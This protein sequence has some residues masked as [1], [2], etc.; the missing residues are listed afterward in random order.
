MQDAAYDSLLKARRQELHGKIARVIEERWPY[1]VATEPELLAY[2][3]TEAKQPAK[4]IPLWQQAGSLAFKRMALAEAIAHLNKGLELVAALPPSAERDGME[5]DLRSL[6]GTAWLA[7]RG[8]QVQE[9]WD[10]LHPALELANSLRRNDAL[11]P[12]L[13]GL[14]VH[15]LCRG[16]VAESLRWVEEAMNAAETHDDP[17][18]LIVGHNA[19]ASAYFW[20]GDPIKASEHADRVLALYSEEGQSHLV[21]YQDPKAACLYFAAVS[22]W[23]LGYPDR[24]AQLRDES[25]AHARKLGHS[26]DLGFAL[27]EGSVKLFDC[28]GEPDEQLKRLV[29]AERLGRENSLPFLMDV[30]VPACSG[31]ALIRAGQTHDGTAS[32]KKGIAVWEQGGGRVNSPYLKYVLAEG[33]AQLGDLDGALD[34]LDEI[35]AQVERPGWEERCYYAE[36][37][38]TKG[39]LLSL[40]GDPKGAERSYMASLDWARTQQA[41]SWELRTATS[42]ARLMRDQGRLGEA[43][44]LL[45]PVRGWFTEGFATKDLREA[46]ALLDELA[47][48]PA[49]QPRGGG[50]D[51]A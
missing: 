13:W 15:V 8:W 36:I 44:E 6:L 21:R 47:G 22:T 46:K 35:I 3:Y 41:K 48:A 24:A 38:R 51:G 10:S 1:I 19:A 28:R 16:R 20:L 29:E 32:L 30:L 7:L 49:L 9:V 50:A 27:T 42:Y 45:A 37:L 43:Y 26:V 12:I 39:W 2:H 40:K 18:L 4:A 11:V 14:F 5:L 23:M 17:Y 25:E 34:L 33:I 31:I